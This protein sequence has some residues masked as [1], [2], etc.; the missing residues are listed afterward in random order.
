M[1]KVKICRELGNWRKDVISE[2]AISNPHWSKEAG[3]LHV[4]MTSVA[5]CGN[6]DYE[7]LKKSK[8]SC[9]GEHDDYT[10]YHNDPKICIAK[11]DNYGVAEFEEAYCRMVYQADCNSNMYKDRCKTKTV[12]DYLKEN[13]GV[14]RKELLEA[15]SEQAGRKKI[16][17]ALN[18]LYKGGHI[19]S[20]S[21]YTNPTA[22]LKFK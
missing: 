19:E 7:V 20:D 22:R 12:A 5:L 11:I 16:V 8:A 13:P 1:G 21:K 14:Q 2:K 10:K 15:L 17:D 3:G 4:P 6:I 9:S 18:Y